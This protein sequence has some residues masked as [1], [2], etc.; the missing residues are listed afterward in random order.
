MDRCQREGM[1][2]LILDGTL[3]ESDRLAGIRE[4]GNDLWFSQQHKAFG[5]NIQILSAPYG[6]SLW[7]S[8]VEP[9]ST[10]DITAARI[11]A[12]PALYK[13][14][15]DGLPTVADKGHIG[16]GIGI[17]IPVRRP[18]W[19]VG[20]G[21][22]RRHPH[23]QHAAAA[24]PGPRRAHRRRDQAAMVG[25]AARHAQPQPDRRHRPRHFRPQR[26]PEMVSA[27]ETS[28]ASARDPD[29]EG[30]GTGWCPSQGRTVSR[31]VAR[32]SQAA[33]LPAPGQNARNGAEETDGA[34]RRS[35]S[36]S[37]TLRICRNT[38]DCRCVRRTLKLHRVRFTREAHQSVLSD[39]EVADRIRSEFNN[40]DRTNATEGNLDLNYIQAIEPPFRRRIYR[41]FH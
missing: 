19:Q 40:G 26:T 7:V 3:I 38:Q 10:P 16:A 37:T 31:L 8:D 6:S 28:V 25:P 4:N 29:V 14:A 13:A 21:A 2:N 22:S 15:A 20:K 12:R 34:S 11:H 27:E 1:S 32:R 36:A 23:S 24:C 9:G 41:E 35:R 33:S 39:L 17:R 18:R 5:G 30:L